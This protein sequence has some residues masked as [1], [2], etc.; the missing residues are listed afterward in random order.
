NTI[1]NS[2]NMRMDIAKKIKELRIERGVSQNTL[3]VA[4]GVDRRSIINWEQ[5]INE[6]K[7]FYIAKLAVY[8]DVSSDYLLGLKDF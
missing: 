6:P 5:G 4:L 1:E 7:A 2:Y 3:A 8:F